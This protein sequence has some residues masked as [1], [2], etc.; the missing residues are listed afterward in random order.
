MNNTIIQRTSTQPMQLAKQRCQTDCQQIHCTCNYYNTRKWLMSK[1]DTVILVGSKTSSAT[2]EIVCDAWNGHS[3]SLKVIRCCENRWGQFKPSSRHLATEK[4][5]MRQS[6][7]CLMSAST[8]IQ[9]VFRHSFDAFYSFYS[10][11]ANHSHQLCPG[12]SKTTLN[13]SDCCAPATCSCL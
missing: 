3:R 6:K 1:A 13:I 11:T 9:S 2:A 12:F 5:V 10:S 8:V 4:T 7:L